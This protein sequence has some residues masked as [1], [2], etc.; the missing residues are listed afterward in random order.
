MERIKNLRI[1]NEEAEAIYAAKLKYT[2][3]ML[4]DILNDVE[5]FFECVDLVESNSKFPGLPSREDKSFAFSKLASSDDRVEG[6]QWVVTFVHNIGVSANGDLIT[7]SHSGSMYSPDGVSRLSQLTEN[8]LDD[9]YTSVHEFVM[10]MA[11]TYE[12]IDAFIEVVNE[13]YEYVSQNENPFTV[14]EDDTVLSDEN[15]SVNEVYDDNNAIFDDGE[16]A[17]QDDDTSPV[18]DTSYDESD[19]SE[20]ELVSDTVDDDVDEESV[21]EDI[22]TDVEETDEDEESFDDESESEADT[23]ES[24]EEVDIEEDGIEEDDLPSDDEFDAD[25]EEFEESFDD[26]EEDV[27]DDFSDIDEVESDDDDDVD[28]ADGWPD[29]EDDMNESDGEPDENDEDLPNKLEVVVGMENIP[30]YKRDKWKTFQEVNF[31]ISDGNNKGNALFMLDSKFC[32]A[33]SPTEIQITLETRKHY[34][35]YKSNNETVT[36]SGL[37]LKRYYVKSKASN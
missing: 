32:K 22:E 24:D 26:S 6:K 15:V 16:P 29:D 23:D 1:C 18:D 4:K 14:L 10:Y 11:T 31:V 5:D 33:I 34:T 2:K 9:V 20:D 13:E 27:A 21:D 35:V 28:F 12:L 8:E 30:N 17:S 36:L 25:D 7:M 37:Q 19:I 3:H